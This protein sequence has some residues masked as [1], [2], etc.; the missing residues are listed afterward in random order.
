MPK[1]HPSLPPAFYKTPSLKFAKFFA[2]DNVLLSYAHF[3][4][5]CVVPIEHRD[6]ID[7]RRLPDPDNGPNGIYKRSFFFRTSTSMQF[8]GD[9]NRIR[10]HNPQ[11]ILNGYYP[12]LLDS[13][14]FGRNEELIATTEY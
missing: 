10:I 12:I 13:D 6:E 9:V 5:D 3:T 7:Y 2:M 11:L 8:A 4:K 1:I 14:K